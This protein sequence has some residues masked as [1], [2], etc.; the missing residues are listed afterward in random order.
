MNELTPEELRAGD[1]KEGR[2]AYVVYEGVVYDVSGSPLWAEGRHMNRHQAGNDLTEAFRAAPHGV[3]VLERVKKV[4]VLREDAAAS[5][6]GPQA[7]R[8]IALL[9][10]Q[11]PHPMTVHFPIAM[12]V[13]AALFTALGLVLGKGALLDVAM[14]NLAFG[15]VCAP[16]TIVTGLLSRR[17]EHGGV[18]KPIFRMK[19][20]L[21]ALLLLV[22]GAIVLLQF[23][24][25]PRGAS[26][27]LGGVVH[28][29]T[30]LLAPL[31]IGLG[32]LGGKISYP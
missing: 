11:H 3:E 16:V 1:G 28:L 24:I 6:S 26:P 20:L 32:F 21:S 7:P 4:G 12:L 13:S 10:R 2:P 9:L 19:M 14:Y 25:L 23:V 29:G 27:C 31:V 5:A 30:L 8:P 15:L 17:Y 18:R 22:T